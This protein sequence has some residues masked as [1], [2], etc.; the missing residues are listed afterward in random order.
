MYFRINPYPAHIFVLK[1]FLLFTSA[2]YIQVHFRLDFFMEANN[3]DPDQTALKEQSHLGP[4]CLQYR[5]VY[6]LKA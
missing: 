5:L 2:A 6:I 1:C 3:M 4:F